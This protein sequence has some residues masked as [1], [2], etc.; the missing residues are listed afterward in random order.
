MRH[1]NI[2][3]LSNGVLFK[4]RDTPMRAMYRLYDAICFQD[5]I[6]VKHEVTYIC[7]Q[8]TWLLNEWPD[9]CE[10]DPDRYTILAA[11]VE[12]LVRAIN[13]RLETGFCREVAEERRQARQ[14]RVERRRRAPQPAEYAPTWVAAV[15]RQQSEYFLGAI[16]PGLAFCRTPTAFHN[17]NILAIVD[18]FV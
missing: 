15:P 17:R 11:I 18:G 2:L 1:E 10:T 5:N 3:M 12:E 16:A 9:P 7:Y 6:E 8:H 13:W 4:V 14:A